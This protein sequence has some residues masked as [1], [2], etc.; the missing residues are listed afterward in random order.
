MPTPSPRA[1]GPARDAAELAACA[2]LVVVAVKPYLVA[3]VLAPIKEQ[4]REKIVVSVAAGMPFEK[5]EQILAPGTHHLSTVP[6]TPISVGEGII[7]CESRHSLT[8]EEWAL[9]EALFGKAA[10]VQ[11]VDTA[12]LSVAGTLAAAARPLRPCLWRRW[13]TVRCSRA[14]P[15]R[16]RTGWPAR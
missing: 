1:C 16:W 14:C 8:K 9:F 7:A 4:L 6:N 3:E 13:P 12:Q 5:Y 2:D 11:P 15:G 10:L